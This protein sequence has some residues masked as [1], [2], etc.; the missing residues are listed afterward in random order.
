MKDIRKTK[1]H[2]IVELKELRSRVYSLEQRGT[3][4]QTPPDIEKHFLSALDNAEI[5]VW[6]W[7]LVKDTFTVNAGYT[8]ALGIRRDKSDTSSQW[9][10]NLIHPDDLPSAKKKWRDHYDGITP[11]FEIEYRVM[12]ADGSWIWFYAYGHIFEWLDDGTP[13][14]GSGTF[15]NITTRKLAE[16]L[17]RLEK[18][19]I[20]ALSAITDL[21]TA[22]TSIVDSLCTIDH[23]TAGGV[24]LRNQRTSNFDLM[25]YS[26]IDDAFR[27]KVMH[28]PMHSGLGRLLSAQK[29]HFI[30]E[31]D[32][33]SYVPPNMTNDSHRCVV[34]VPV[35]YEGIPIAS[36]IVS[37]NRYSEIPVKVCDTLESIA[38]QVGDVITRL[39]SE[40]A[41]R[42]SEKQL[43]LIIHNTREII[44][45]LDPH[46]WSYTYVSPY[47]TELLGYT[48]EEHYEKGLAFTESLFHPDDI[49][50]STRYFNLLLNSTSD[51][52]VLC[53]NEYRIR[54]IHG[55]YH[56]LSDKHTPIRDHDGTIL[57]IIGC[58]RDITREKEALF[59]LEDSEIK[60]KTIINSGAYFI[61][62][63]DLNH[64][65]LKFNEY[66]Y[67][68]TRDNLGLSLK[69]GSSLFTYMHDDSRKRYLKYIER[70]KRGET[71]RFEANL[72]TIATHRTISDPW[73]EFTI[74][75]TVV[76]GEITGV[77]IY[78]VSVTARKKMEQ[79]T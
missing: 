70:V 67:T 53:T 8:A 46:T 29:P 61:L 17:L 36:L 71:V 32:I 51:D 37:S 69:Q 68:Y 34:I 44:Y 55:E 56:W 50:A 39:K 57:G 24:Y 30:T 6:H 65:I 66:A 1:S 74:N 3:S 43:S 47:V 12:K 14:Q 25:A 18:D 54:D 38:L 5:G 21:Q 11:V 75:P 2:L 42:N 62:M 77:C 48:V 20:A 19:L 52:D 79:A 78:S 22:L 10:R 15:I 76:K 27:D 31:N 13:V 9:W 4:S 72:E 40:E 28:I 7:D 33:K 16:S 23:V 49:I 63:V 73:Y 58:A 60:L 59:K 41:L 26:G 35:S 64:T 45:S